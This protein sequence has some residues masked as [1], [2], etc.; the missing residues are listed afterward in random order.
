M[1]CEHLKS[2]ALENS[3][4]DAE[5]PGSLVFWAERMQRW[6]WLKICSV[7]LINSALIWATEYRLRVGGWRPRAPRQKAFPSESNEMLCARNRENTCQHR[8]IR[9]PRGTRL[10]SRNCSGMFEGGEQT[11]TQR[12]RKEATSFRRLQSYKGSL[13]VN[14]GKSLTLTQGCS[15]TCTAENRWSTSTN[16]IMVMSSCEGKHP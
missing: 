10:R 15:R 7:S 2:I 3:K 16:S 14:T 5:T 1:T 11:Q 6:H 8:Y 9:G 12:L 13:G 4:A